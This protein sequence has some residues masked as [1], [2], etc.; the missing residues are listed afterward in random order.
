MVG[1]ETY[2]FPVSQLNLCGKQFI[3]PDRVAISG[4]FIH[5]KTPAW[6]NQGGL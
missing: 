2:F 4:M 6:S 3:Y 5:L 1:T